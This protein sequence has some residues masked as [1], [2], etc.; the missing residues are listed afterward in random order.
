MSENLGS[1]LHGPCV[2][3]LLGHNVRICRNWKIVCWV[4]VCVTRLDCCV[5]VSGLY[6]VCEGAGI[7][8]A[9]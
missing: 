3:G 6:M 9:D 5:L 4:G 8:R 2:V 7:C 1:H